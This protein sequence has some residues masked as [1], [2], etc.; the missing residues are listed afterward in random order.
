MTVLLK[1]IDEEQTVG[2][3]SIEKHCPDFTV[4]VDKDLRAVVVTLLGTR[5]FPHP[6][7]YDVVM[8]LRAE[9][10]PFM[11]GQAHAGMVIGAQN[12]MD[13]SFPGLRDTLQANPDYSVLVVGYSLGK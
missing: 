13:R 12:I 10:R 6:S 2:E 8:D 5:I 3:P 4:T 9:T 11:G 7:I 1:D